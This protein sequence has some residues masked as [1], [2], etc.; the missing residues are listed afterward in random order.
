LHFVVRP[1]I[2]PANAGTSNADDRIS[3]FPGHMVY[4]GCLQSLSHFALMSGSKTCFA[5]SE[6]LTSS[7]ATERT[8]RRNGGPPSRPARSFQRDAL[9]ATP[10]FRA[11][12]S[13]SPTASS[14]SLFGEDTSRNAHGGACRGPAGVER[15]VGD[16]LDQLLARHA[17]LQ[18]KL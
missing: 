16:R 14:L 15:Q 6:G 7:M 18:C 2:A 13:R 11:T 5:Q 12:A 9:S 1:E 4:P 3:R 10:I 17:I 8:L